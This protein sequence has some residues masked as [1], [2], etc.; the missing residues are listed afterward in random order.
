MKEKSRKELFF[1]RK[2][3]PKIARS[4]RTASDDELYTVSRNLFLA[5]AKKNALKKLKAKKFDSANR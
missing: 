1:G 2:E 5:L 4:G 3:G